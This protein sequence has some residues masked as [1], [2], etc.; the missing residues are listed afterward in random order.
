MIAATDLA[1]DAATLLA[2]WW[3]RPTAQER[4]GWEQTWLPAAQAAED[5]GCSAALVEQLCA[6]HL[7]A[8]EQTLLDE[9][10]RLFVGPG[11]AP[12]P[13]YESIWSSEVGRREEGMLMGAAAEAVSDVYRDLGLA[14]RADA[15]ELPD[16]LLVE[17]EALGYALEH[18]AP[19][20]ASELLHRH[21]GRWMRPFCTAAAARTGQPFYRALAELTM[22]W[23][24]AL[25]A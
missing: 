7:K 4:R 15:G 9:Y 6:A 5:L 16:H 12:C 3:S 22:E 17:W 21:L 25:T 23:T 1:T 2:H 24:D 13:P 8:D 19:E 10:E 14:M 20:A 18:D 11:R